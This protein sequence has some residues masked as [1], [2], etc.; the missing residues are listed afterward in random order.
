MRKEALGGE[1]EDTP[2][3]GYRGAGALR[4]ELTMLEKKE[5]ERPR[6]GRSK[7]GAR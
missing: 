2:E 7:A 5:A 4:V 3:R 6:L 1:V